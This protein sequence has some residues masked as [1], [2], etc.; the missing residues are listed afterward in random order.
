MKQFGFLVVICILMNGCTAINLLAPNTD[1]GY[2]AMQEFSERKTE[3][4]KILN[5]RYLGAIKEE[6]L[7]QFGKPEFTDSS[8]NNPYLFNSGCESTYCDCGFGDCSKRT[9]QE[10]WW[11]TFKDRGS[12][13]WY[14]Y[15]ITFFFDDDRVVRVQ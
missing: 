2:R 3:E 11:Y 14:S 6:I 8:G 4:K 12:D 7:D 9:A 15:S 1:E 10:S 5:R 13:G